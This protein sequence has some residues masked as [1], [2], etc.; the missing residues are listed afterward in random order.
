MRALV[1]APGKTATVDTIPIPE[2]GP[3]EIRIKVHAFALNPVDALYTTHQVAQPGRVV[4]SDVAGVVDQVGSGGRWKVGDRVAGFLQGATT[5]T[6]RPGGFAEYAILEQDLAARIPESVSFTEA[7]TLPLCALTAAQMI[8]VRIGL[9]APFPSPFAPTLTAD[10]DSSRAIFVYAGATSLGLF[11]I[12]LLRAALPAATRIYATASPRNHALLLSL[13]AT[14]VFDYRSPTWVA[15]VLKASG[16]IDGALDCISED[17]TTANISQTFGPRG[18]RIAVIR[19]AAWSKDG[20]RADVT[21]LYG[22]V[23]EG[24]GHDI[25]YNGATMAA[26]AA[27]RAFSVG[28]FEYLSAGHP[29]DATRFP[30]LANPVRLMPG[31]LERVVEDAFRL[32][33]T[34]K[35]GDRAAF[36]EVDDVTT[37]PISAEK[38][39]YQLVRD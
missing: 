1:L 19:A 23:W 38:L 28:F 21:P 33:G 3:N 36:V 6:Q 4:G 8:F 26:S 10:A 30:I 25:E 39:V 13:G 24:L 15:D 22:A 9:P 35:L 5:K 14:A 34:G 7:S 37:R 16:G 12:Q 27:H 2:P 18:G 32:I 29:K 20:V 31:G 11:G 17:A